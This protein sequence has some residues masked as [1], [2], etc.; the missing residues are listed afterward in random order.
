VQPTSDDS[1]LND[2]AQLAE[3]QSTVEALISETRSSAAS[4]LQS[5]QEMSLLRHS[6]TDELSV[7]SRE[8]VSSISDV[9]GKPT[10]LEDIETLHRGLKELESV[11]DYVRI[12]ERAL[13]LRYVTYIKY[14]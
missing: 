13:K 9:Q 14:I 8:M 4:H 7:L 3:S 11:Q 5:A 1:Q 6:L 2:I 10:L 12:I